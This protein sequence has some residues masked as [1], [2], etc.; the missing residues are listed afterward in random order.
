[1]AAGVV[2]SGRKVLADTYGGLLPH[3][4]ASL[5]G[6][7][8]LKSAR[9]GTAMARAVAR[10]LVS[11][12]AAGNVLVTVAYTTGIAE[13]VVLT[14][15]GGSGEDLTDVVKALFDFRPDAIV[16]RLDLRRPLYAAAA[17]FGMF[18]REG[19]PWEAPLR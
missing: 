10:Q 1:F 19:M 6:K 7:D 3:G 13:P 2:V 11:E 14:A 5:A 12:G 9:A 16:E 8:P 15:H 18:G 4:G 17:T